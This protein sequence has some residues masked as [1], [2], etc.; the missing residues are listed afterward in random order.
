MGSSSELQLVGGSGV[1]GVYT[2]DPRARARFINL[3]TQKKVKEFKLKM[4]NYK[5]PDF[6]RMILDLSRLGWTHEKIAFL[7][8]VSGAST[9]SEW[10]RGGK[11]NYENG[12]AFVMLWKTETGI[13]R[14]PREGEWQTY[15]YTVGQLD[16]FED[17]GLC[18]Q[19]ISELDREIKG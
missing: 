1:N 2:N 8:P 16:I 17:G 19:V 3:N 7:L 9:V 12:E 18:D 15:K 13:E 6:N 11:P 4:R 5:R 10:A 14:E